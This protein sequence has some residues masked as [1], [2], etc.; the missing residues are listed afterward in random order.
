MSAMALSGKLEHVFMHAHSDT[1]E[2]A[3]GIEK[4]SRALV[5]RGRPSQY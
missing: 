2:L 4:G 1:G 5:W 3:A